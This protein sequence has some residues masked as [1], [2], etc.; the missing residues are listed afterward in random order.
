LKDDFESKVSLG[1]D[2]RLSAEQKQV[3]LDLMQG[4]NPVSD[5]F[6]LDRVVG[7]ARE[8]FTVSDGETTIDYELVSNPDKLK[9]ADQEKIIALAKAK[10]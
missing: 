9:T 6:Y 5:R 2:K 3:V 10:P 1:E 7:S 8:G 4:I